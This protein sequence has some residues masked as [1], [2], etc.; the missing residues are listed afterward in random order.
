MKQIIQIDELAK[1][2]TVESAN[3]LEIMNQ[4][5]QEEE[6]EQRERIK[7]A[8]LALEGELYRND[9]KRYL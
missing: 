9:F 1:I 5:N 6:N 8:E 4:K 2:P 3:E 7:E